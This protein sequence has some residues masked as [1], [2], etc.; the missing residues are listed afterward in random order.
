[1]QFITKLSFVL[2]MVLITFGTMSLVTDNTLL[3]VNEAAAWGSS[4][5][6]CDDNDGGGYDNPNDDNDDPV[7]EPQCDISVS[8]TQ[9][10]AGESVT[11]TWSTSYA[12]SV[13]LNG[14]TVALNGSQV[15]SDLTDSTSFTVI[16][17]GWSSLAASCS[18]SVTVVVTPPPEPLPVCKD[19]YAQP[20]TIVQ[21]AQTTLYWQSQHAV[22]ASIDQGVGAVPVNGDRAV[23]PTA[24][25]TYTLTLVGAGGDEVTCDTSVHV[26]PPPE[27][28]PVCKDFYAQPSTI[29]QGAQTTLYWQSQ[30]AV[31]ASIDQGVG[32]VP[33][34]GDRAVSPTADT[35]YTLTLV[36]AG[37]DEV[38]C[39][40]SVHV[41]PQPQPATCDLFTVTPDT[42]MEGGSAT[43]RW[44][45]TNAVSVTIAPDIGAV[46]ATDER[47]I[48]PTTDTT[49]T[50]TAQGVAGTAPDTCT[51]SIT[52]SPD[53]VPVCTLTATPD[54]LPA[55]GG[56][57]MLDW[58]VQNAT[59]VVIEPGV[60]AV[61]LTGSQAESVTQSTNFV[62][63]ATD[64]DGDERRC[65]APVTVAE[66]T[67]LS[68]AEN[69]DFRASDASI[70]EGQST[71]LIWSTNDVDAVSISGINATSLSGSETV[72]PRRDTTYVLTATRDGSAVDCPLTIN[73]DEDD[74]D[75]NG[76]GGGSSSPRC[77]LTISDDEIEVGEEITIE[78]ETIRAT[79][80]YLE[81]DR[82]NVLFTTDEYLGDEKEEYFDG[83]IELRPTRDTEFTLVA[84]RGRRDD[85]CVVDVEVMDAVSVT[86]TRDREPLVAGIALSQ[87]PYTGFEAGPVLTTLFYLLLIAWSLYLTYVLVIRKRLLAEGEMAG[88]YTPPEPT[89]SMHAMA[90]AEATRPDLFPAA[91]YTP[92]KTAAAT[93]PQNLPTGTMAEVTTP[94]TAA[95][96]TTPNPLEERAHAQYALLSSDAIAYLTN[97]V[98]DA[99]ER[100]HLLD[101]IIA[102]AKRSYPLEDGWIV[103]NEARMQ[104]LCAV[105]QGVAQD[106]DAQSAETSA[107]S[108]AEAIVTGNVL[109][110]YELI[111]QRPMI[112]LADAAA[113][114]DAL[115]RQRRGERTGVSS[116]LQSATTDL[117]DEQLQRM[118]TALTGAIDGTYTDESAAV[119]MAIMKAVKE[120]A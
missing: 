50:L 51:T 19:F 46:S 83:S 87:V 114:L 64:A 75:N 109:A 21:G 47:V 48:T 71:T 70:D 119:K 38:T 115:V 98:G 30:H 74:D 44:E 57:V 24:D 68:C 32:A 72:S 118:I 22:S 97:A 13:T 86:Q 117:S 39:D 5:G 80:V 88:S 14:E 96:A 89:A 54:N 33:V 35:T 79:E 55:G 110:A 69:V 6:S 113:D 84:E 102:E 76:G 81:D 61:D 8:A 31:S 15:F 82:G 12:N 42:I 104:Q 120:V 56:A 101:E 62:L 65:E 16:G 63:T 20:S 7:Y 29:V 108:L 28:L 93:A 9:I 3:E 106:T 4:C 40:T 78:W 95:T 58:S 100:L 34:N 99:T 94:A 41:T 53:T 27:P 105:C 1:M 77:E 107:S 85:E 26:T 23:S 73:V 18:A 37:G 52:V 92:S 116:L 25:T 112:A 91:E 43:L 2:V 111:G 45:T 49:Y 36:G 17:Q 103:I 60:G 10:E 59:D 90:Q 67:P 11:V 66:E